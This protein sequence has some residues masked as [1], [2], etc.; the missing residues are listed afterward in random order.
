MKTQLDKARELWQFYSIEGRL[1]DLSHSEFDE[2]YDENGD[3]I[4][5]ELQ[6]VAEQDFDEL[7]Q[8]YK[9]FYVRVSEFN[10]DSVSQQE[11]FRMFHKN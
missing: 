6:K 3:H 2:F 7:E 5:E 4:D 11:D 9:D 1:H 10:Y 8:K